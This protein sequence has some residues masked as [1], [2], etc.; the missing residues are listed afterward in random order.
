M[1]PG[2][3]ILLAK[4]IKK[5]VR[6]KETK[7]D[8]SLENY[9]Q[10]KT[11]KKFIVYH[12]NW[13]NYERNFNI[14]DIPIDYIPE[15]SYAFFNIS[16]DGNIFSGDPW[17]DFEKRYISTENGIEPLDTWDL[18]TGTFGNIG[19]FLK[20][21][22]S[23]KQFNLT[24]SIGGWSW[25]KYFSSA[26]KEKEKLTNSI[27]Q[28][29]TEYPIFCGVSLDWEYPSDDNINYG[30]SENEFSNEDPINLIEFCKFFRKKLNEN[31]KE[32]FRIS[33]CCS[34][35][36][37]TTKLKYIRELSNYVDEFHIM[38][39]DF[40]GFS[41]DEI[42]GHHSN[43]KKIDYCKF[44]IEDIVEKYIVYGIPSTKI[45]IGAISYSRSFSETEGPGTFGIPCENE[46]TEYRHL[47]KENSIEY[48][49]PNCLSPFSYD[50]QKK[51]YSS[52]DNVNSI[53]YKSK[54]VWEKDLGGIIFW[55]SSGDHPISHKRSLIKA[56]HEYLIDGDPRIKTEPEF[57]E[58][59]I[60]NNEPV[61]PKIP[62]WTIDVKYKIGEKVIFKENV[63]KCF[64]EH[65]SIKEW[66][67]EFASSIWRIYE[68]SIIE[69]I[70]IVPEPTPEIE[71]PVLGPQKRIKSITLKGIFDESNI[72]IEYYD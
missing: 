10:T 14:K 37:N 13:S 36:P 29:L 3:S 8:H 45:F 60:I 41:G 68:D 57:P 47:P 72:E 19:Q 51:V 40:M 54:Y 58:I 42:T 48:W 11:G 26:I 15:I 50:H 20:L 2:N 1:P 28:F 59:W 44:S 63:Y 17:A 38:T 9:I 53:Y 71:L 18:P 69:P 6:F 46:V 61:S 52:Y 7:D 27:I 12:T 31:D 35:D 34:G 70:E 22:E 5:Q 32:K 16:K 24:L 62:D 43:L 33:L 30:N 55:E 23:G 56:L 39:Y 4:N 21:K 67:P 64:I 49:D 25:S 66:T 65:T